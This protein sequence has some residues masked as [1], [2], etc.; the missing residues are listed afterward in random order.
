ME[1]GK[2]IDIPE[3]ALVD[4]EVSALELAEAIGAVSEGLP[5]KV[6]ELIAHLHCDMSS[7]SVPISQTK[8]KWSST[9]SS[10]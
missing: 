3:L 9:M 6:K 1:A 8:E 10:S 2:L 7:E 5:F 4:V